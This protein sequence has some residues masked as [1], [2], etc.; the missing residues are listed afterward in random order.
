M[1]VCERR[2]FVTLHFVVLGQPPSKSNRRR[3][4]RIKGQPRLIRSEETLAFSES[5]VYQTNSMVVEY[6][7]LLPLHTFI[8]FEATIYYASDHS[9]LSAETVL[10]C[11]QRA[12]II[13]N[14]RDVRNI[15]L[16]NAYDKK[17][18]RVEITISGLSA[19]KTVTKG[20]SK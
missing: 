9:D 2:G 18:P 20:D 19:G 7:D 14:D 16:T 15:R 17:N 11:C 13:E 1:T 12:G 4:V 3:F 8:V 5:F 6:Q 10:D